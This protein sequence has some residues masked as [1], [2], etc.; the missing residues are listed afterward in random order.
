MA[1]AGKSTSG[2]G[3]GES[4]SS[5]GDKL[6]ESFMAEVCSMNAYVL[7]SS[8]LVNTHQPVLTRCCRIVPLCTYIT[9]QGY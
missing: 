3:G 8:C 7:T 5:E 1:A 6:L 9:G 4:S 2:G